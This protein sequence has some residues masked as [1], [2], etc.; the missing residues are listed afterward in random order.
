MAVVKSSH[1]YHSSPIK[2]RLI[3]AIEAGNTVRKAAK[4]VGLPHST[5]HDIYKKFQ[6]TGSTTNLPRSGRP[7]ILSDTG[8]RALVRNALKNRRKPFAELANET[9]PKV[10]TATVRNV[11]KSKGYHRRVA[12]RVPYL[13][14]TQKHKRMAWAMVF[15]SWGKDKWKDVIFSDESYIQLDDK[16]GRVYVTRKAHEEMKENCVVGSFKQ[17]PLRIMVWGCI[18]WGRKGPL[19]VLEYPG[20]RGHG[21]DSKRYQEQVLDQTLLP[22]YNGLKSL[23][24]RIWFQQDGAPSHTSKSTKQWFITKKMPLLPHP[25]SS[26]DVNPM[27]SVWHD[28][29]TG[30]RKLPRKPTTL[31]ELKK[32]VLKIWEEIPIAKVNQYIG[33]MPRRVRILRKLRGGH[34]GF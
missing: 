32:V 24:R 6:M 4:L 16:A 5:A 30:I 1:I 9:T 20:G 28:L 19:I 33:S 11:L 22:F 14:P 10:S 18:K 34:T 8:K 3:G 31:D 17:S 2:N 23:K 21:M 27:E 26:P 25:P 13:S 12:R 15:E 7:P 29:K